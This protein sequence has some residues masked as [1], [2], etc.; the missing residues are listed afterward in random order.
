MSQYG[1]C[2]RVD[3]HPD[4]GASQAGCEGRGCVWEPAQQ[5]GA[6][7]CRYPPDYGYSMVGQPTETQEGYLVHLTRQQHPLPAPNSLSKD[8]SLLKFL[9]ILESEEEA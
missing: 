6:P 2:G 9:H 3:C 7:W 1:C 8:M 5:T 4:P